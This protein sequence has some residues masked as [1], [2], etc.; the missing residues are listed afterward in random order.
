M[1]RIVTL[2]SREQ[3]E[4]G[5]KFRLVNI[6]EE[7]RGCKL[8]PV[9]IGRL[10]QGRSYRVVEVR[11]SVGQRCKITNGEMVPVAVEEVPIVGLLPFNKALEG[12]IVTFEGEC[13]G[14]KNCPTE[15][16]KPGE[17][18]KVLKV[19]GRA[20]CRG[21]DFAIVEFYVL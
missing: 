1:K 15:V 5:H 18:V 8:Y 19:L 3:A 13:A 20:K 6:P 2:L 7:C 16:V 4:V 21:K 17:K 9:C 10:T 12:A 14:C 11:P